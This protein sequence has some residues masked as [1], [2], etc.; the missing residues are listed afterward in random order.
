M[1]SLH[2]KGG[3]LYEV[4]QSDIDG[5]KACYPDI[6]VDREIREMAAWC[7][8]NPAKRKTK[9][10]INRFINNWLSKPGG[11]YGKI[12]NSNRSTRDMSME[13]TLADVSW[14]P[15]SALLSM[16]AYYLQSKGFYYENGK[17]HES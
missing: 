6:D 14:V 12:E 4:P 9:R 7:Y 8:A 2:L 13:E 16:R 5:F 15:E 11:S 1:I 3:D 10:G 17:R